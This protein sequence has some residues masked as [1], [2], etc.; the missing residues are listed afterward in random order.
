MDLHARRALARDLLDILIHDVRTP[1]DNLH[2]TD[3]LVDLMHA[4]RRE[5]FVVW[6]A[7]TH[8]YAAWTR[9]TL[10]WRDDQWARLEFVNQHTG[11]VVPIDD[12][13]VGR[14]IAGQ[15]LIASVNEDVETAMALFM[16]VPA[17]E[18][19]EFLTVSWARIVAAGRTHFRI[20]GDP[21][22]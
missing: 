19:I 7:L 11:E 14:R 9:A 15:W 16:S 8:V 3:H 1:G 6:Y 2:T 17:D 21:D 13:A 20:C 18:V 12:V 5:A 22:V 10:G 4:D